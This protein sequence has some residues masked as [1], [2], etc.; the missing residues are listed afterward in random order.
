MKKL[1]LVISAMMALC[2]CGSDFNKKSSLDY[3]IEVNLSKDASVKRLNMFVVE[4]DSSG[5]QL[6]VHNVF[7]IPSQSVKRFVRKEH[8][9]RCVV[10]IRY[11]PY[12]GNE[13][14][15]KYS[16]EVYSLDG[17]DYIIIRESDL[18]DTKPLVR[19]AWAK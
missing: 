17:E 8:A 10:T 4:Y 5:D 2:S 6:Y 19:P 12:K 11:D 1:L 3:V 16:R 9:N 7:D 14:V 15:D 18:V 13:S